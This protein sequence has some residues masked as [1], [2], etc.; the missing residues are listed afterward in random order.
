MLLP[1]DYLCLALYKSPDIL[2]C[3]IIGAINFLNQ[4]ICAGTNWRHPYGPSSSSLPEDPVVHVSWRDARAFCAWDTASVASPTEQP[5]SPSSSSP[6]PRTSSSSV[7]SSSVPSS[8]SSQDGVRASLVHKRL[9]TEVEWELA[10]RGGLRGARF[11]W[12]DR[13]HDEDGAH[14]HA[15]ERLPR[16][17]RMNIWTGRFPDYSSADDGYPALAPVRFL[18]LF[19]LWCFYCFICCSSQRQ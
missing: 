16:A 13:E 7:P 17:Y 10:C 19:N 2:Y 18:L 3:I 9:P 12:G 6:A 4:R 5:T 14:A 8:S 1:N 15:H 11:P